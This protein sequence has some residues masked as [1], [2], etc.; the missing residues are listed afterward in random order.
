MATDS[1]P[2]LGSASLLQG[3]YSSPARMPTRVG[4]IP[5][6]KA[7]LAKGG[8]AA[9][10]WAGSKATLLDFWKLLPS[11]LKKTFWERGSGLSKRLG[12]KHR[13]QFHNEGH[14]KIPDGGER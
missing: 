10:T 1:V 2:I 6:R 5:G 11:S 8:A 13:G 9:S 14:P 3:H 7:R 4:L 12:V